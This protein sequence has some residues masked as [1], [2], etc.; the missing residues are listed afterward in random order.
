MQVWK[1]HNKILYSIQQIKKKKNFKRFHS[2][3]ME[4]GSVHLKQDHPG[5]AYSCLVSYTFHLH[6]G[7]KWGVSKCHLQGH[8]QGFCGATHNDKSQGCKNNHGQGRQAIMKRGGTSSP[9]SRFLWAW[10][11]TISRLI[12]ICLPVLTFKHIKLCSRSICLLSSQKCECLWGRVCRMGLWGCAYV[13]MCL[14]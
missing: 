14:G 1:C 7:K 12:S 3:D 4:Q 11:P 5:W 6:P 9:Q 2:R 10:Q 13:R 8:W